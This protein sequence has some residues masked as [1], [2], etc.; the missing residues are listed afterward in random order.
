M[1]LYREDVI[2]WK[3]VK[4]VWFRGLVILLPL[5]F[6]III[7]REFIELM[8]GLATPIADLM[9]TEEFIAAFPSIEVLALLLLAAVSLI[10]GILSVIPFL[11]S[12]CG[13]LEERTL[14]R[15]PVYVPLKTLLGALLGAR[16]EQNFRPAFLL[17]EDG[18]EAAPV[19][20]VEDTG[21]PRLGV[22][23]PRTPMSFSGEMRWVPRDRV[24]QLDISFDEF[25][26][27]IGHYGIGLS[28]ALP[29]L[30]EGLQLKTDA[31]AAARERSTD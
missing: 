12:A 15:L 1:P 27:A 10:V 24:M 30:P 19:Y 20:I 13:W 16:K 3:F 22:L 23:Q 4:R 7:L 6:L 26:L 25:S 28:D 11:A 8:I 5:L 2:V 31:V 9:F 14:D 21:R 17:S 18:R 29:E